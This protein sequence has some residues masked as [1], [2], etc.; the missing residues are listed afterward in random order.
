M[1]SLESHSDKMMEFEISIDNAKMHSPMPSPRTTLTQYAS[2]LSPGSLKRSLPIIEQK[3]ECKKTARWEESPTPEE[4]PSSN[5]KNKQ[6]HLHA[7]IRR[8]AQI[9]AS[10]SPVCPQRQSSISDLSIQ[11]RALRCDEL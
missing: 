8:A 9:R 2:S 5:R 10:S 3:K 6:M 11:L 1:H 7:Q 4:S